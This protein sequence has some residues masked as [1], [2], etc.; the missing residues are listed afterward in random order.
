MNKLDT[1]WAVLKTLSPR[2]QDIAADAILDYAS[3][4]PGLSDVQ[5]EEIERR[6][7]DEGEST[8][9]PAELRSRI[10]KLVP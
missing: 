4:A 3:V 5:A 7:R 2:E 8:L 10:E 9:T 1:A 6:L